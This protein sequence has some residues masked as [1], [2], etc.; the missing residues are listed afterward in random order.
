MKALFLIIFSA[1]F[2]SSCGDNDPNNLIINFKLK[3]NNEPLVM[4]EE[5]TYPDGSKI[6]FTRISFYTSNYSINQDG[7]EINTPSNEA[8]YIDLT[9][10]HSDLELAERGLDFDTGLGI[11]SKIDAFNFN[12]GVTSDINASVPQD[13]SSSNDLSRTGEYWSNW[14]SYVF[15]KL[16]GRIDIDGDGISE[17]FALHLGS[18][19]ALRNVSFSNLNA[20]ENISLEIDVNKIFNTGTLY[21]IKTTPNIHT[22]QQISHINQ[23]MDNLAG[24][25]TVNQ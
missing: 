4:F 1:F 2:I 5:V 22:L 10:S 6:E 24:S 12:I 16:E 21:D 23:L 19:A 25:F 13:Y 11:N 14:N 20:D 7:G 18:D 8:Y 3:Y 9:A 17:A 15:T